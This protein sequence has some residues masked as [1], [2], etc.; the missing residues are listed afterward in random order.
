MTNP[1]HESDSDSDS[2]ADE[3][4]H[5]EL[6]E[7]Q[8]Q[9]DSTISEEDDDIPISNYPLALNQS[10]I[11]ESSSS[12]AS[13]Q[14][15][16]ESFEP[17]SIEDSRSIDKGHPKKLALRNMEITPLTLFQKFIPSHII[18]QI[19]MNTNTYADIKKTGGRTWKDVDEHEIKNFLGICVYMGA[20]KCP[21]MEEYWDRSGRAPVQEITKSISLFRFQ[22]I[23]RFIHICDPTGDNGSSYF[24]NKV[25]PLMSQVFN[26]SKHLW[27]P[28]KNISVDE[29][30]VMM[31]GRSSESVRMKNKPI[32]CGFKMWEIC[33]RGYTYFSFPHSNRSPWRDC[34]NYK[35]IL[36]HS[37]AVVARLSDELPRKAQGRTGT[38][39][40]V[41]FM[42]NY[43]PP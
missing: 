6:C 2:D 35:N 7:V 13:P 24:F 14:L 32:S 40:Y 42:D 3:N 10:T 15:N 4:G 23:K 19:I 22:E 18:Q 43:L 26:T 41:V 11:L 38:I 36:P 8:Q 28:G 31:H 37:S 12:T 25:E 29:M 27:I 34:T 1:P 39:M 16:L 30:M 20:F 17:R 5:D 33:D 21:R 9:E